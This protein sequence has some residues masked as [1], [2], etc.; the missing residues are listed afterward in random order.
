MDQDGM[1]GS[2]EMTVMLDIRWH[3]E[4]ENEL[5]YEIECWAFA[6]SHQRCEGNQRESHCYAQP[7][8]DKLEPVTPGEVSKLGQW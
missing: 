1:T 7:Q 5:W 4:N 6:E 2:L 3:P 8:W